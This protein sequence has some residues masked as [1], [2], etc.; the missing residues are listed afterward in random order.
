MEGNIHVPCG[1]CPKCLKRR[2]SGWSFR[3][4][5]EGKSALSALFV[6]LTYAK[7]IKTTKN[8]Y[9]TLNKRDAQLFFKKLRKKRSKKENQDAPIKYYL[10]GEYGGKFKRPHFHAIVFNSSYDH[11]LNSWDHG[12]VHFG[13]V[14][15]AS[16]G[17]CLKYMQKPKQT[18]KHAND[19]R[20]PE[21]SL[22]SK[23][24]GK[25]IS[26]RPP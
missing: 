10:C 18:G 12:N 13:D 19:D 3:L 1:K 9:M 8:G 26:I 4:M 11:V 2:A 16:I 17:Y 7:D 5:Q 22:M 24:L 20:L 21:F 14:N 6:T 15:G 25:P 23:G